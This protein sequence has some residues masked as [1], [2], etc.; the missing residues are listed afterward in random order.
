MMLHIQKDLIN[1]KNCSKLGG[2]FRKNEPNVLGEQIYYKTGN[3]LRY[4]RVESGIPNEEIYDK[5]GSRLDGTYVKVK[6]DSGLPR[7]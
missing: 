3:K 6:S 4:K 1:D 2:V 5:L 7:Y